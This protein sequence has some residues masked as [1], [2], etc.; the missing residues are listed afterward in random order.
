MPRW[1]IPTAY[2]LVS[3]FA[4][5]IFPRLEFALY[6]AFGREISV[7]TAQALLGA[8]ASGM[9]AFTAIVFS[10]GMLFI[11]YTATAFSKRLILQLNRRLVIYHAFGVFVATFT[12]ALG[13]LVFVNRKGSD[14][15]P[16]LSLIIVEL[17]LVASIALLAML[18]NQ[19][20]ELRITRIIAYLGERGRALIA[21]MP[22]ET[23]AAP[24][25]SEARSP[26]QTVLYSGGL[27]V[28]TAI[29]KARLA[30]LARAAGA[31]IQLEYAVGDTLYPESVLAQVY[32]AR[33][34]VGEA[35]IFGAMRLR[36]ENFY[37]CD[38]R[39]SLRLL[40]D[41]A[42]MALSPAVNDPTTAVEALDQ[43]L[44][45]MIRLGQKHESGCV[46]DGNGKR[47][48]IYPAP[49]WND[50]LSLAFDE[51]R[52]YGI[53]ALQVVRRLRAALIRLADAVEGERRAAVLEYRRRLDAEVERHESDPVDRATALGIDPQGLGLTRSLS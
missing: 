53:D 26:S 29:D 1:L 28:L 11:Q 39:F 16:F 27:V 34:T 44:D 30:D 46:T 49:T 42:I 3:L 18:I 36:Q 7:S 25:A 23:P 31:T 13:T 21:L 17:L 2:L 40:V 8:V 43:I 12:F 9:M 15:I 45:L 4:A 41:T 52:R 24:H 5:T 47:L 35:A 51:I 22:G 20:A 10:I 6:P 37:D 33:D 32:G 38:V 19:V 48:L 50:Y 14:W